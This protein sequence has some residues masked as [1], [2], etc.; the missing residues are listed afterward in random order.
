[1][2]DYKFILEKLTEIG[3]RT[4]RIETDLSNVKEDVSNI[5]DQDEIQNRL[6]A[7]H[8]A[9][10]I[11]NRD[12]LGIEIKNREDLAIRVSTLETLPNFL[13]L[14]KRYIIQIVSLGGALFAIFEWFKK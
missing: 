4:A 9:G 10:T 6:L 11:T 13:K 5:K 2:S 12:R 7:E 1:M 14:S 3:E 8:I